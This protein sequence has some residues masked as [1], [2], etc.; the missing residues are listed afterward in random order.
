MSLETKRKILFDHDIPYRRLPR[1]HFYL[2]LNR[3]YI[4]SILKNY[5]I[6]NTNFISK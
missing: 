2:N 6:P 3:H 5:L 1:R 4:P